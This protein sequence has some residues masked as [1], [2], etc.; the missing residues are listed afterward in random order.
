MTGGSYGGAIALLAAAYDRRIDAIVPTSTWNDLSAVFFRQSADARDRGVFARGW[1][2]LF[3]GTQSRPGQPCGRLA[4]DV[5]AAYQDAAENARPSARTIALLKHS[6]PAGVLDR[7]HAPTLLIQGETDSLFGLDQADAN[8]AGI[9]A[10]VHVAWY[11]GGHDAGSALSETDRLRDLTRNW[12]DHWLRHSG[13]LNSDEF[14]V[15]SAE[16]DASTNL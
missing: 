7:I 9:T 5:C 8:A 4:P 2:G 1:A 12:F 14:T 10:P 15:S 13:S 11:A 3:F 6:S 16:M